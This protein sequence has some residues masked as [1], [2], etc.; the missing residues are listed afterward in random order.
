MRQK[1]KT[2]SSCCIY[3]SAISSTAC[4]EPTLLATLLHAIASVIKHMGTT[5]A[6]FQDKMFVVFNGSSLPQ[7]LH[8]SFVPANGNGMTG[9]A[10]KSRRKIAL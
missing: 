4:C 1:E 10:W 6:G 2:V 9:M 7:V 8:T 5:T 3:N